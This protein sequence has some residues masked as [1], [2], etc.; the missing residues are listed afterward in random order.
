MTEYKPYKHQQETID[1]YRKNPRAYDSSDMGCGKTFC[2]IHDINYR[3][4]SNFKSK[5]L[6]LAPKSLLETVW[7]NDFEKF[8]PHIVTSVAKAPLQ[9]KIDAFNREAHVYITNMDTV[10]WLAKQPKSFW[11]GFET[12]VID[13]STQIKNDS[14]R[15]KA[16]LQIKDNFKYRRCLSGTPTAGPLTDLFYQYYFLDGGYSLGSS[17]YAFKNKNDDIYSNRPRT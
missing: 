17:Y 5:T 15:T 8:T 12:I 14:G 7:K 10:K 11:K 6:I 2:I 3:L 13:E 4:N 1:F 9:N 16:A